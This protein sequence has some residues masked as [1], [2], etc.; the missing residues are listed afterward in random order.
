VCALHGGVEQRAFRHRVDQKRLLVGE[1]V[2]RRQ[3]TVDVAFAGVGEDV[4]DG[5]ASRPSPI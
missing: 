2:D 5:R 1:F 3:D 4:V